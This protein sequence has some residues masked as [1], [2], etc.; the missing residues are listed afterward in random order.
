[1]FS[2][3]SVVAVPVVVVLVVVV[4]VAVLSLSDNLLVSVYVGCGAGF[5]PVVTPLLGRATVAVPSLLS[6]QFSWLLRSTSSDCSVG[7]HDVLS[8]DM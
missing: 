6:S 2:L 5:G 7:P 3:L 8:K 4:P 1:M